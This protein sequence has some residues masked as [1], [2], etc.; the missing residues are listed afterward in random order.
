MRQAGMALG[1]LV[2]LAWAA[3]PPGKGATVTLRYV[4]PAKDKFV[5]ESRVTEVTTK[6]GVTYTSLTDR[7]REKMTLTIRFDHKQQVRDAEA[8]RET[9][10]GKQTVSVVAF[11]KKEATLTRQGK[12]ER[13]AVTPDVV[14]TTAPDWSDIFQVIRRYDRAKG[15]KQKFAG[16]WIHPVQPVRQLTFTVDAEKDET[17]EVD[18]KKLALRRYR[19][20]LRSGAYLVWADRAGRVYRLMP[21]GKP[22]AAVILEG[23]EKA[24]A[25]LR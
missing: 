5:L 17:I 23:H 20:V 12:A 7:G 24:T 11:K 14:V 25:G 22:A 19:V 8:V 21:P 16:L 6:D 2:S 3:G 18:G 9:A 13:L 15:G 10:G 4:R 1:L